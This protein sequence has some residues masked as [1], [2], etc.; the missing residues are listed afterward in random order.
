MEREGREQGRGRGFVPG[1]ERSRCCSGKRSRGG[2]DRVAL[3]SLMNIQFCLVR[4]WAGPDVV[5]P[6][7]G[8]VT[9]ITITR[10]NRRPPR[11][12]ISPSSRVALSS[13]IIR[14]MIKQVESIGAIVNNE[15]RHLVFHLFTPPASA[16]SLA[17]FRY[18]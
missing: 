13:G 1:P 11:F 4:P 3:S 16:L 8:P 12:E 9:I 5:T 2:T 14:N 17:S 6:L 15:I 18:I 7:A 10:R